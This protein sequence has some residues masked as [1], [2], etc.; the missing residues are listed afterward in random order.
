MPSTLC[1]AA[2]LSGIVAAVAST[3]SGE[4]ERDEPRAVGGAPKGVFFGW[5]DF[6]VK[7]RPMLGPRATLGH[8]PQPVLISYQ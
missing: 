2:M 7:D 6:Y 4:C 1:P 5:K 8:Q 3:V